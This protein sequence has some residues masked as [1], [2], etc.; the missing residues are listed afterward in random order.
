MGFVNG[1]WGHSG[2]LPGYNT[3]IWYRPEADAVLVVSTN[4]DFREVTTSTG[5][6]EVEPAVA[7]EDALLEV[8]NRETPLGDLETKLPFIGVVLP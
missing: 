6:E 4:Y 7:I 2:L 8:A 5:I 3:V 1:W